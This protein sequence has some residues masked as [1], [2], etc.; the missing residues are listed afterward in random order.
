[1]L[2]TWQLTTIS[3]HNNSTVQDLLGYINS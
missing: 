1:M 3:F 2:L